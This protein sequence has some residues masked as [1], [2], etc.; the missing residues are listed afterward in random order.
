MKSQL[1][2]VPPL[3][4]YRLLAPNASI[5]VSPLYLGCMTF[6]DKQQEK[7][8]KITK[9]AA[10]DI[11]DHFYNNGGN[12]YDTANVYQSRSIRGMGRRVDGF[13]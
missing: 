8:G 12:F 5:R 4:R 1:E 7:Y 9:E 3:A 10:F 6:G 11:L 2:E 13:A